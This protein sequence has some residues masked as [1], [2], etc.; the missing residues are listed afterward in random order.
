MNEV[1]K[2]AFAWENQKNWI[3]TWFQQKNPFILGI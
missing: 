1:N 2:L 3:Q